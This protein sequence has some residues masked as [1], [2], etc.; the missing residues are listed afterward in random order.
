MTV[1][2]QKLILRSDAAVT[3]KA[4]VLLSLSQGASAAGAIQIVS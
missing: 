1:S 3:A 2:Q 4:D